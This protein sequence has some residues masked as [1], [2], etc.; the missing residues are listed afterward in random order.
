LINSPNETYSSDVPFELQLPDDV[1]AGWVAK[2]FDQERPEEPHVTV[3]EPAN[4]WTVIR[5]RGSSTR[6]FWRT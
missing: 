4:P 3:C 6:E 1:P 5:H 2:I